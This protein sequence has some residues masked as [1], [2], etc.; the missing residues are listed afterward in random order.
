M[1]LYR[2][3][4]PHETVAAGDLTPSAKAAAEAA[5]KGGWS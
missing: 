5:V 3:L 2:L 1:N 4:E